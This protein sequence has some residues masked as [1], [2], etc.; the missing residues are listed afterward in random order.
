MSARMKL[1]LLVIKLQLVLD[2]A[3]NKPDEADVPAK[4]KHQEPLSL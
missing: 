3:V 1:D 2:G 4:K